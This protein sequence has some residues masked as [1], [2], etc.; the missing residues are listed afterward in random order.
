MGGDPYWDEDAVVCY[1]QLVQL[2]DNLSHAGGF[3][4]T[5]FEGELEG[6]VVNVDDDPVVLQGRSHTADRSEDRIAFQVVNHPPSVL[7]S[8]FPEVEAA[9]FTAPT[10]PCDTSIFHSVSPD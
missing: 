10:P 3:G 5:L 8:V 2:F 1:R 6:R 9:V 7:P 4:P